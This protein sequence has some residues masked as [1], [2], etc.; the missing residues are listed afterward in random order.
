[1]KYFKNFDYITYDFTIKTDVAPILETIVDLTQRIQLKISNDDLDKLCDEYVIQSST[2]PEQIASILYNDPLLHWTIL[3]INDITN[4]YSQWPMNDSALTDFVTKK[5][6]AG[7]EYDTNHYE[8][9]PERLWMDAQFVT[10]TY[11]ESAVLVT[12]FDQEQNL[13]EEKRFIKVIKPQYIGSFVSAFE[14]AYV[15]G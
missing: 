5:Y 4:M 8:K 13:N 6:G 2:K 9:M 7:H 12:N 11:G 10:D 1:M 15:N 14:K 3:Y